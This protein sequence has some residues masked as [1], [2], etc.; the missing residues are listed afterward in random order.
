LQKQHKNIYF[1]IKFIFLT[2]SMPFSADILFWVCQVY[3]YLTQIS[4][5]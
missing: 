2:G 4:P 5:I 3:S 1:F